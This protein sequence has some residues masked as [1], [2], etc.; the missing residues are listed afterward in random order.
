MNYECPICKKPAHLTEGLSQGVKDIYVVSCEVCGKYQITRSASLTLPE[1]LEQR[2]ILSFAIRNRSERGEEVYIST[3]DVENILESVC[4]PSDPFETIDLLL[5]YL[6][7]KAG[8]AGESVKL[9]AETDYPILFAKNPS[10]FLY[11]VEKA[12]ELKFIEPHPKKVGYRLSL[13]GWKR[14]DELRGTERKSNQAFVAMWFDS[15]LD[16]A[17]EQG[18]RPALKQSGF[19]P[20]RIDLTEHNEKICDRIIAEIRKSGLVVADFTGQRGGV[21]FEAGFAMGLGIPVIWTCRDTD[22]GHVHFDTR[23]YNHIVWRTPEELK[24]KLINRIEAT[25]PDRL[26]KG[27]LK[28][29]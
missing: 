16:Q 21:Y 26:R 23:Q 22:I 17:W 11:Y 3:E 1:T 2:L 14:L 13:K 27:P 10:E 8:T 6:Y 24:K 20:I 29:A 5:K 9:N 12:R 18:F 7:T 28:T 15:N 19:S 4:V 25:L